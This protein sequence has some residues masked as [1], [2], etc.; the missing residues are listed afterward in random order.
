MHTDDRHTDRRQTD[1][2]Q[3][4][5]HNTYMQTEDTHADKKTY[6]NTEDIYVHRRQ[7]DTKTRHTDT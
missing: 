6:R 5:I 1:R 4:D 2:R 7:I 3:T